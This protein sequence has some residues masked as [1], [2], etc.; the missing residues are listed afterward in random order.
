MLQVNF[1]RQN[2]ELVLQKLSVKNF[3]ETSLVDEVL[4]LDDKRKSLK[5]NFDDTQ[6]AINV[7]S[8][9]I[10]KLMA[11]GN[12]EEAEKKKADVADLK[13]KLQPINEELQHTE[14]QLHETLVRIPNLP[15]ESVPPGT[16][17]EDNVIVREGG[18]KPALDKN[19]LPHWNLA[20]KYNLIDFELGNKLT[21]SGFPVYK[22][23]GAKLQRS[24]ISY[25]LD[26]NISDG[27]KEFYPPYM[28]NEATAY[29]T[30]QLPDKEGQMYFVTEDKFYLIPTAE[31][32]LTNI[33]RDEIISEK[34]LPV[35]MTAF[36]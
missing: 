14:Q 5:S 20:K 4:Q 34:E 7:I 17:P 11:E 30:G 24:L 3:K 21:G 36:T 32:P 18:V 23:H 29:G 25:F 2:K 31:V 6:A 10:G 9:G 22:S 16:R 12:R 19:A 15:H 13:N 33:Y 8:K 1:I 28:V 26:Y 27:Y 35:K